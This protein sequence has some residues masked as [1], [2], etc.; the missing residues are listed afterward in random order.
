MAARLRHGSTFLYDED[1]TDI[2][3]VRDPDGSEFYFQRVPRLGVFFD[4]TTQTDSVSAVPMEFSTQAISRG[5]TLVGVTKIYVDRS[6][7]Y[8]FTLSIKVQNEHSQTHNF[9]LW[10]R[11]NN[12]D[13]PYSR[14]IYSVPPKHGTTPGSIIPSQNFWLALNAGDYVEIV[15]ATDSADVTIAGSPVEPG[16][17]ISPA[18]LLTVKEIGPYSV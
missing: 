2:V 11:L 16:K 14:F 10:G 8:E 3:G 1:T 18:L 4:T 15:W 5:V 9:E 6:A 13:I 7:L 12:V 17:P